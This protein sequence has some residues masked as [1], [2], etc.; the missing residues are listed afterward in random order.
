MKNIIK[1]IIALLTIGALSSCSKEGDNEYAEWLSI[2][3]PEW[4]HGTWETINSTGEV[5][6]NL[7]IDEH[8]IIVNGQNILIR[9]KF[10]F[11]GMQVSIDRVVSDG[12]Y[13]YVFKSKNELICSFHYE[14]EMVFFHKGFAS[15]GLQMH[16][17]N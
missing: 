16:P 14:R 13:F 7:A 9:D 17:K 15:H 5:I 12:N 11:Y 1:Y 10:F 4:M 6:D 3:T 2:P 8:S